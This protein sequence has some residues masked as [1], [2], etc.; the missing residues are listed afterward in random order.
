[1]VKQLYKVTVENTESKERNTITSYA[2]PRKK[3]VGVMAKLGVS[4]RGLEWLQNEKGIKLTD[5]NKVIAKIWCQLTGMPE[6]F[7]GS[8]DSFKTDEDRARWKVTVAN[9]DGSNAY[10]W[11]EATAG[12]SKATAK[13]A[14]KEAEPEI[15]VDV[16][17]FG[18]PRQEQPIA[19]VADK[20]PKIDEKIVASVVKFLEKEKTE[21]EIKKGLMNK[22]KDETVVEAHFQ[23][24]LKQFAPKK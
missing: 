23:E 17:A 9:E 18:M 7:I 12:Y 10:D 1:M 16:S 19:A 3:E 15:M 4:H 20:T 22:F 13:K 8:I 5:V 2:M 11:G 6:E 24:G 14:E 21:E